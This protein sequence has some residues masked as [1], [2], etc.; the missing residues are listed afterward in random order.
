MGFYDDEKN[1]QSYLEMA[2]GYDGAELIQ[3]LRN[4]LPTGAT[5]LELGMGPGK[6]LDILGQDYVV[7]GSDNS[8]T[9]IDL[10]RKTNEQADLLLLDAITIN[11][12]RQFDCIY[13]NK[14]LHH[15]DQTELK[16]SLNRQKEVVSV[17]GFL[18]HSFWYGDHTEEL[19]GLRFIYY[20]EAILKSLIDSAW[21]IVL[22]E[23]YAEMEADDSVYIL[24]KKK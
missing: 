22:M 20:T 19:H 8:Q 2:E 21:E 1:V 16:Q 4:Y 15:L 13:S 7:T 6:D 9:F 12:N 14:V 5:V 3:I 23:R 11:T 17:G 10:Y 18:F 24:L